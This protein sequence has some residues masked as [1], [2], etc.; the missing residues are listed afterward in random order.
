MPHPR[1]KRP[2]PTSSPGCSL[3]HKSP[4]SSPYL[5]SRFPNIGLDEFV[6]MPNH[7]HGIIMIVDSLTR[8]AKGDSS[9][10]PAIRYSST[11]PA[12]WDL[13]T[14][15]A[16][17]YSSTSPAMWDS[18]PRRGTGDSSTTKF[19][20]KSPVPLPE[21]PH[22]P[23][24]EMPPRPYRR[25]ILLLAPLYPNLSQTPNPQYLIP[26]TS[27]PIPNPSSSATFNG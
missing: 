20:D 10:R 2:Y 18:P 22:A 25:P 26:N 1:K 19:L 11:R 12:M 4:R 21:M 27:S 23:L 16:I 15:P 7:L 13:P 3:F 17:R 14:R 9:S 24:P 5:P 8:P 6:I